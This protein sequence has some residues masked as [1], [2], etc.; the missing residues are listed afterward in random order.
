M[1]SWKKPTSDQIDRAIALLGRRMHHRYFFERLQ[2]PEWVNPLLEKG[3]FSNLPA[4]E[5]DEQKGTIGFPI[6]PE[7][8]YL[9]RM[10]SLDPELILD[11]IL[12]IPETDN[13]RVYEDLADV[14]LAM[15]PEISVKLI[16]K[17]KIWAQSPYQHLL[18]G[19]LGDYF[20]KL[21]HAGFVAQALDL[22]K[23]IL[24]ILPAPKKPKMEKKDDT[25]SLPKEPT[26]R[27]A[28]SD[29][30]SILKKNI[31]DLVTTGGI[32]TFDL[33]CDLL[34]TAVGLSRN[35]G[36]ED[37]LE[38]YSWIWRPAIEVHPQNRGHGIKEL[39][40]NSVCAVCKA[41]VRSDEQL[42]LELVKKLESRPGQIFHRIALYLLRVFP[43]N[44][45][46]LIAERLTN[47]DLFDHTSCRHE[48]AK[49]LERC[50]S[51]LSAQQQQLILEWIEEGPDL[52]EFKKTQGELHGDK[53]TDE[54][55]KRYKKY[56]QAKRLK[57]FEKS[58]PEEW[59]IR[60]KDLTE[61]IGVPK[62]PEFE[63]DSTS[64][65]GPTSPKDADE[66]KKM[67]VSD[68][69]EFLRA[70]EP[71]EEPM[72]PSH[73][74]L[75][76]VL[77]SIISEEP[78][79]FSVDAIRFTGLH[80]T[81]VRAFT[82]GLRDSL[83]KGRS[84]DWEPVLNLCDWVLDQP[85]ELDGKSKKYSDSDSHW[86]WTLKNIADLLSAGFV[87]SSG[88]IPFEFRNRVW[89]IIEPL[90]CDPEPT[91]E[92]EAKYD[93]SSFEPANLAINTTRGEAMHTVI[94]YAL[95]IRRHIEKGTNSKDGINRGFDEMREVRYVLEKHLDP[96]F[97]PS[98]AIR[99]VYGRW[100][101]WLVLLDAKWA[102]EHTELIFPA[103]EEYQAFLQAAWN[104]Y[105]IFCQA[106]D[107][108]F[109]VLHGQY[110]L[111]VDSL[112]AVKEPKDDIERPNVR[113]AEHLMVFYWQG[114]LD[115]EGGEGLLREFWKI[116]PSDIRGQAIDYV[117][118]SLSN[119]EEEVPSDILKRLK[120]LWEWRLS[121]FESSPDITVHFP[122]LESFGW[123]FASGKFDDPWAMKQL[124]ESLAFAK[125]TDPDYRVV[126]RL[127]ELSEK[128][129]LE[130]VQC[131][132]H[133]CEG[134]KESWEMH[135]WKKYA[136]TILGN[137]LKGKGEEAEAAENLIHYLGSRGWIEFG[138]LLKS[139]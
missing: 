136:K 57:W 29:Y 70:W 38:D 97:D 138:E 31:P 111:A 69:A 35:S 134:D 22:A 56:W 89:R 47:R 61:K 135:V 121:E 108:V 63:R 129:P 52:E 11:I 86:G 117:G 78:A 21:A 54:D 65:V 95:W 19:K 122:E 49:L 139:N 68:I 3:Y 123:W 124:L 85:R 81:Y 91:P 99:S 43:D 37:E 93:S 60:Y 102:R 90:T 5:R 26:A 39:I 110:K 107:N 44:A 66:I 75:G 105:L 115:L 1:K 40:L 77:S 7:S 73:E 9:A 83:K 15:P 64:W 32:R 58:L 18:A 36:K 41:I 59:K 87:A 126:E 84:F 27:L 113:L 92:D 46:H 109:D 51:I 67:S 42:L 34:E 100:F 28:R 8:Q 103:D 120:D 106:Y 80:P 119:T 13:V 125:K 14:A 112:T 2:N 118:R 127:A 10:A 76:R 48:Y 116:A 17:A 132:K 114:T 101:P 133:L 131:L 20:S 33:L 72:N 94:Q 130:A 4:L 98:L 62:H 137:A 6:W 12:K 45:R 82:S 104:T 23:V 88:Y 50:F 79:R 16:E 128:M 71:A 53:P 25:F 74:G 55:A 96:S 24:Q 30:E